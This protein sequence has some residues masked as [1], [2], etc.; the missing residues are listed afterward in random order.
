LLALLRRRLAWLRRF[1]LLLRQRDS[2]P[3]GGHDGER[4]RRQQQ[5]EHSGQS[6]RLGQHRLSPFWSVGVT[7]KWERSASP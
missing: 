5:R 6:A 2:M 1:L 3:L 7:S 4:G